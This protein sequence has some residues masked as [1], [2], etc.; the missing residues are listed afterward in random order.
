MLKALSHQ[1]LS[2]TELAKAIGL[3]RDKD[4]GKFSYHLK[5]LLSSGLIEVDS[6]SGK[7][8]LSHK[9]V[10]VLSLLE[11]MEEELSDKTLMIV[12]RSD[13]TIEPFDKNKIADEG[14]QAS[15]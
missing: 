6:S 15:T 3:E 10:K 12:R 9:G 1:K 2:Y 13:Q 11:R 4:A 14:G 7:Y 8:T 5:K